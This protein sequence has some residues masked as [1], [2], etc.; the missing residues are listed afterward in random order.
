MIICANLNKKVELNDLYSLTSSIGFK[1]LQFS[2]VHRGINSS[3]PIVDNSFLNTAQQMKDMAAQYNLKFPVIHGWLPSTKQEAKNVLNI[4]LKAKE[5]LNSKYIIF[6]PTSLKNL[7][8]I[9]NLVKSKKSILIEN[10]AEPLFKMG[11]NEIKLI[12]LANVNICFDT[13]HALENNMDINEILLKYKKA[14]KVIHLSDYD[15]KNRHITIGTKNIM[16]KFINAI[17][18]QS[19]VVFE[20]K[21]KTK[22]EYLEK[23]GNS[24][25][26]L[27]KYLNK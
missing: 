14:I 5:I 7:D 3:N 4:Y 13:C 23:Y 11:L 20:H 21:A 17:P 10:V 27:K 16:S 15:G 8:T 1:N 19:I 22:K 9:I 2:F 18:S 26:I 24:F 25:K 12:L 6:H